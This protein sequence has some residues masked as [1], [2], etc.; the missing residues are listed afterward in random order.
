VFLFPEA[1]FGGIQARISAYEGTCYLRGGLL[2]EA[3]GALRDVLEGVPEGIP[4]QKAFSL[5]DLALVYVRQRELERAC[6][7]LLDAISMTERSGGKPPRQRIYLVRR[8]LH[9]WRDEWFVKAV[10][11]R[12]YETAQLL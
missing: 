7:T 2:K 1:R 6:A 5:A 3:E 12:L 9:P 4:G 10:D 11:E 8:E